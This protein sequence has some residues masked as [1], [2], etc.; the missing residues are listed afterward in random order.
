MKRGACL[1][2]ARRTLIADELAA[3]PDARGIRAGFAAPRAD[4]TVAQL[5]ARADGELTDGINRRRRSESG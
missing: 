5:I 2:R 1:Y 3:K 4:E